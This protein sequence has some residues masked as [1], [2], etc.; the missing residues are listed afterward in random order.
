VIR[1]E[2]MKNELCEG[3]RGADAMEFSISSSGRK[4]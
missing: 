2:L 1:Q 4:A 3:L